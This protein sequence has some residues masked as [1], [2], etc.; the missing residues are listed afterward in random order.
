MDVIE[1][2]RIISCGELT[3]DLCEMICAMLTEIYD[4]SKDLTRMNAMYI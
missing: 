1:D 2:G 4:R 3:V